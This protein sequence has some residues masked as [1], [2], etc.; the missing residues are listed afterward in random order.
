MSG[1]AG[2]GLDDLRR[3]Y[4]RIEEA[5]RR[6]E[7]EG[8]GIAKAAADGK[9]LVAF[10]GEEVPKYRRMAEEHPEFG[11]HLDKVDQ[12][13]YL[14]LR[15]ST[16]ALQQLDAGQ[17]AVARAFGTVQLSISSTTTGA[18]SVASDVFM[19]VAEHPDDD[20]RQRYEI[21][22]P[23]PL[24]KGTDV[25]ELESLLSSVEPQLVQR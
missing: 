5:G 24:F 8:R 9:E 25:A 6:L 7:A 16:D 17:E 23:A 11:L 10:F 21:R 12:W 18:T 14:G 3:N 19:V 4:C 1:N 15:D 13:T 2:K 20:L 22:E